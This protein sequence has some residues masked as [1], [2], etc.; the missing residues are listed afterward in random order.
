MI[1]HLCHDHE[2]V[3]PWRFR[4]PHERLYSWK[5]HNHPRHSRIDYA[6]INSDA[7][8]IL[9][10]VDYSETPFYNDHKILNVNFELGK[11]Q[12]GQGYFRV[13]NHLY[14]D[15]DFISKVNEMI[16]STLANSTQSPENVLDCIL[17]NTST[18]A[19]E[20]IAQ[21]KSKQL[22]ERRFLVNEIRVY[23]NYVYNHPG[24]NPEDVTTLENLR[25]PQ[26]GRQFIRLPEVHLGDPWR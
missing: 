1:R 13:S 19:K 26:D 21:T 4:N 20:H 24:R 12:Q 8:A 15:S 18:I 16:D 22:A 14:Y 2:L 3:D 23:K 17:F 6:L 11:Y 9:S 10:S 7:N 5:Q 25:A